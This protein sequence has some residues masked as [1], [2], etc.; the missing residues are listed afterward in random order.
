MN[1]GKLKQANKGVTLIALVVTI[2]VLLI[3]AG[4][5]I[6]L[7]FSDNG[8]IKKAQEAANK[9]QEAIENEQAQ[10]NELADYMTNM[11]NEKD[12][13]REVEGVTIPEGFYYVGG[14]KND[15]IVIS[16]NIQDLGKGTS[17]EVA[18]TLK[19]NQFVWIP[20]ENESIFQRYDGY[21]CGDLESN[22]IK[23]MFD[24]CSE[25]YALGYETESS[26]YER[27]KESV[28]SHKGF[29]VGRYE[30]GTL[31]GE[32]T[33]DSGI[34]DEVIVKQG[35]YVYNYIGW[36]NSDD[37]TNEKGGAVEKAKNFS[38]D[39]N[40][41]SVTSTLIYGIEW[42]AIMTWIDPAYTTGSC[43]I[44]NSYVANS[45]GK[46]N[47]NETENT[48]SWKGKITLTGASS[49]YSIKNI[50]DL[51][52]NVYEWSMEAVNVNGQNGIIRRI[53]RGGRYWTRT[54]RNLWRCVG[55]A[56]SGFCS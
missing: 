14:S 52:G 15:G 7:V 12:N 18:K 41:T 45:T 31:S 53:K 6:S 10:M 28:I 35:A 8:I 9:T 13:L 44:N 37:M 27:M 55:N 20:V 56:S 51:A 22:I 26:E 47:Y 11:L 54:F 5:T 38:K 23:E 49:D 39:N 25:P 32:R 30:A 36:S 16:D 40:Y 19:G 34:E 33:S 42:D 43:D 29:Y 24:F 2:V 21:Y 17:H 3:L 4:I 50:Y 46:G 48:N 1:V